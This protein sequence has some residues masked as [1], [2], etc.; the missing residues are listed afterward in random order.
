[1]ATWAEWW[2]AQSRAPAQAEPLPS[3]A[4]L[5]KWQA[6]MDT[7]CTSAA[8]SLRI[9]HFDIDGN[10]TADTICWRILKTKDYGELI[11]VQARV[12][13]AG[14]AQTAYIILPF[15]RG[16][17]YGIC[18]PSDAIVAEQERW[19]KKDFEE[20]GWDYIGP[21]SISLTGGDCDTPR[22]FWPTGESGEVVEFIFAR[23]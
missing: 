13:N 21:V 5:V 6:E 18:G 12:T 10:D 14:K 17:Q 16:Y 7:F 11:D 20:R 19:T 22:L 1:M 8:P 9:A 23:L 2:A 3:E 15:D 4:E